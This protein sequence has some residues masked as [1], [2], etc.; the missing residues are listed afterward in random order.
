M[1]S[2]ADTAALIK[3][4][5]GT[6]IDPNKYTQAN[7]TALLP[8]AQKGDTDRAEFDAKLAE[9]DKSIA[10]AAASAVTL[11]VKPLERPITVRVNDAMAEY[12][13]E[14]TDP[15]SR[16]TIGKDAVTVESTGFVA[17]K[18]RSRELI[19]ER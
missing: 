5:N 3:Q 15:E 14:F 2:K 16:S 12:G 17:E 10:D 13:G 9:F 11:Q 18:L 4:A 1:A 6:E 8:L 19:E 7:L